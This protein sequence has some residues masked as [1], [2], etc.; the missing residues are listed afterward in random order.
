MFRFSLALFIV[1]HGLVHLW[2]VTLSQQWVEFQPEMG[3]KGTSWL[4]SPLL[5]SATARSLGA[6]LYLAA[7]MAFVS[8][9]IALFAQVSW[10][11]PLLAGAALFSSALILLFWEGGLQMAVQKG[12]L[13]LL[14]NVALLGG[15]LALQNV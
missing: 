4:F 10:W 14:I 1:L 12:L 6:V 15:A 8:G 5:G 7:T 13:G 3:W 9:G 11:R 2:Y